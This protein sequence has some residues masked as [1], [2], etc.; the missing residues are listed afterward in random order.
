[1]FLVFFPHIEGGARCGLGRKLSLSLR[2]LLLIFPT[3]CFSQ[4][5]S[6]V[7][8]SPSP[9]SLP[10][11]VRQ[12][13]ADFGRRYCKALCDVKFSQIEGNGGKFSYIEL[14]A[15]A[16]SIT[17]HLLFNTLAHG[18][19]ANIFSYFLLPPSLFTFAIYL[20]LFHQHLDFCYCPS[21]A[22]CCL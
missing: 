6:I 11:T 18:L 16:L 22:F 13:L 9:L 7:N 12:V 10:H 4:T 1:M 3:F 19:S 21:R 5:K 2:L 20:R 8:N 15:L 14:Q 17:V